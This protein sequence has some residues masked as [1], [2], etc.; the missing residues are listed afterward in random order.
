MNFFCLLILSLLLTSGCEGEELGSNTTVSKQG[1]GKAVLFSLLSLD[2]N[3]VRLE[4]LIGKKIILLDFSTIR[5][6]YCS[7]IIPYLNVLNKYCEGKL[8]IVSV[9]IDEQSFALKSYV[10]KHGVKYTVLLDTNGKVARQYGI[11]GVPTL[12]VLDLKG[13][14]RY[15]GHNFEKAEKIVKQLVDEAP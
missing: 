15:V 14:I 7:K 12:F 8:E 11:I 6:P 1:Y 9:Y 2:G 10:Q 13:E 5:C 4:D 3:L